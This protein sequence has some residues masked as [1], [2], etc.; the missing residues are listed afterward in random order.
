MRILLI[1]LIHSLSKKTISKLGYQER[2]F[3]VGS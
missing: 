2:R 3:K 1:K